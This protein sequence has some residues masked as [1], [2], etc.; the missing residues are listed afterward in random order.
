MF[1]KLDQGPI[2]SHSPKLHNS[3]QQQICKEGLHD[4]SSP[5]G[6]TP[7]KKNK[8]KNKCINFAK[9]NT[10][11]THTAFQKQ[12][13]TELESTPFITV[14][15]EYKFDWR[16]LPPSVQ[17]LHINELLPSITSVHNLQLGCQYLQT[18]N[19]CYWLI[20]NE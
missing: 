1:G 20:T 13:C 16:F 3:R 5:V 15:D 17:H 9:N 19:V 6:N 8:H 4:S 11:K 10:S 12:Q 14:D 2:Y 7:N 18:L